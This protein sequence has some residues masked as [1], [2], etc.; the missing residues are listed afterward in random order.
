MSITDNTVFIPKDG[1]EYRDYGTL[2]VEYRDAS[3][4]YWIHQDSQRIAAISV[5][6]ALKVL[7]KPAL[8][9]WA[10]AAGATGAA[11]LAAEGELKDVPYNEAINL[12]R[13]H[14][15]GADA[16]RDEGAG[17]GTLV[18]DAL[19]AYMTDGTPPKLQDFEPEHRGYVQGI[20]RWL[21]KHR[22]EPIS[23]E[24][25]VA[26]PTDLFA[27]RLDLR[28]MINGVDTLVDLK[29]N[30]RGRVYS[31]AH[32][33]AAAYAECEHYCS[34][35]GR[36]EAIVIVAVGEDGSYEDV[37]GEAEYDDFLCVLNTSRVMKR[38]NGLRMARQRVA[39]AEAGA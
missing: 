4:R 37:P 10:E 27:G 31:E 19:S 1:S 13:L 29:T 20:S 35:L 36:P 18:H 22:P 16:K 14:N 5:T 25:I 39:D 30:P 32:L 26:H 8:I 33:Q 28:A 12:V 38:L 24:Q 7:D 6:S 21:V 15:L 34:D 17:R 2:M 3:H 11:R 9:S 23:V